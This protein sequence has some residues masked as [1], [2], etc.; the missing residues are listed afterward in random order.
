MWPNKNNFSNFDIAEK[1]ILKKYFIYK[2][3]KIPT[4][5][6]KQPIILLMN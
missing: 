2:S 6:K 5:Q 3:Y 1:N 4:N